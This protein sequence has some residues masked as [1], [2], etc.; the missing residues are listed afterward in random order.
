MDEEALSAFSEDEE[1]PCGRQRQQYVKWRENGLPIYDQTRMHTTKA[2]TSPGST[3][4][5]AAFK[6][7]KIDEISKRRLAAPC[8]VAGRRLLSWKDLE[9]GKRRSGCLPNLAQN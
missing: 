3:F 8:L 7:T 4:A 6:R 2:T 1:I 5:F 9:L